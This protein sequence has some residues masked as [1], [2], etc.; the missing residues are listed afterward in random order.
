M[1]QTQ[2]LFLP[3]LLFIINISL[4]QTTAIPD[5]NFEQA[6]IDLN[7][8]SDGVVNGQVTTAD[9]ENIVELDLSN[10]YDS[11]MYFGGTITD[12]TGIEDFTAL[13]ILNI[14]NVDI[15]LSDN[16]ADIFNSN[17]NLKVF[18]ADDSCADCGPST[19]IP[20]LDFSNLGNLEYISLVTSGQIYS[21][22][23]DNPN[24]YY[25]N[26][27]IDLSHE[28]WYPPNTYTVCINVSDAQAASSDQY[29]YNTWNVI[30]PAPDV[31]GYVW[32]D[33]EFSSSCNLSTTDFD[34]QTKIEV[35]PNPVQDRL[36]LENPEQIRLDQ[37]DVFNM[38]GKKVKSFSSFDEAINVES[39]GQGV[40]FVKVM[41][42]NRAKT[43]KVMKK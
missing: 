13:E 9:I 41:S 20:Y 16:Q 34:Q 30:A 5:Q 27:T 12:F 2:L 35:Y 14:S 10:L 26:L 43:F 32:R 25:E 42:K 3:L 36:H 33:Y 4:A 17:S 31:N 38:T 15:Y 8:D 37:V 18:R 6:L 24:S 19:F 23:L 28:Y 21:I 40:Y 1:K 7:I 22:N 39:L 11:L 29:P